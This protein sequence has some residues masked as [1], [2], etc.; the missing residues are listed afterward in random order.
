MIG[1]ILDD[2]G[3]PPT[4]WEVITIFPDSYLLKSGTLF[5]HCLISDFWALI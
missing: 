3:I 4:L 5:R 2:E 1:V